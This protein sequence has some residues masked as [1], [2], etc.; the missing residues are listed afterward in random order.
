[1]NR[2]SD[3]RPLHRRLR[4]RLRR[5]I[6]RCRH[7]L[8]YCLTI[9]M[10]RVMVSWAPSR[11]RAV[12]AALGSAAYVALRGERRKTLGN[13]ELAYGETMP[14]AER[15]RLAREVFR[16]AG[17]AAAEM[18]FL[19]GE[20]ADAVLSR[21]R[22]EGLRHVRDVLE[23]GAGAVIVTAHFGLWEIGIPLLA[24]RISC[25]TGAVAR[26]LSNP[27]LDRLLNEA[28]RDA[29]ARVFARGQ[30]GRGY[31]RYLRQGNV[32]IVLG[33]IDTDKGDGV[34]VPFFGRPAWT[35]TGIARLARMGRA[36]VLTSFIVRDADDPG[37]HVAV[38]NE[39]LPEPAGG[40]EEEWVA[41][42]TRAFT[43]QIEAAVR[44]R[45]E[46]WMWMHRR[47]QHRPS[48]LERLRRRRAV[49]AR[50]LS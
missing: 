46:L 49:R 45:P 16:N 15:G 9:V 27:Y 5:L 14:A 8:V 47:W 3:V 25:E 22:V 43:A 36:R 29:G 37:R 6:R 7:A 35:Q 12:G 38:L 2:E 42:M 30:A 31:V 40:T 34:F 33:D 18:A 23:S 24:P 4:G 10:R 48:D 41:E 21:G 17:M 39:P 13:L 11:A 32:L 1:M 19:S 20:R 26:E 44:E 50:D 28:R